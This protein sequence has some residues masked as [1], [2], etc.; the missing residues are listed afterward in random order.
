MPIFPR[1]PPALL[2]T[3][4]ALFVLL[5]STALAHSTARNP[6]S[7]IGTV[8]DP[9]IDT[10]NHRIHA[11]SNFA[12]S[13]TLHGRRVR[14]QLEPNHN[15]IAPGATVEYI[16]K[17]GL[18]RHR[19]E[20]NREEHKVF[21]G[22][23]YFQNLDGSWSEEGLAR[24]S[25]LRDGE[26]PLFEGMFTKARDHHHIQVASKFLKKKHEFDA[27]VKAPE[28]KAPEEFM[29]IFRDSDR[30]TTPEHTEFKRDGDHSACEA[31][32]L[33]FNMQEDHPIYIGMM[34]REDSEWWSSPM[35]SV[36]S[37]RQL[38][39]Q[40]G[41]NS[42]GGNLASTIGQTAGCPTTRKVALIG[43]ATDCTYTSLFDNEEAVR[44]Q[45]ISSVNSASSLFERTFD[46]SLGLRNLTISDAECPGSPT[47]TA[48]W[49]IPCN[50]PSL[51]NRLNSFSTWR[52]NRPDGNSHWTL[53]TNCNTG[54]AVGLA[55]LGQLCVQGLLGNGTNGGDTVSGANVVAHTQAEWEVLAHETGHTFGAVHD[56]EET[57]C[58]DANF[59]NSQ[60]CCPLN[61]N[62]CDAKAKYIMNPATAEGITDFSPCSIGNICSAML[63]NSV[64]TTCLSS[65]RDVTTITGQQC[66]N[67]IVEEGEDCDCG[68]EAACSD[69]ACCD[70]ATCRFKGNAV[71][72]DSN[73]DCCNNCQLSSSDTVCRP[74]RGECD[75]EERC[76]GSAPV[77][78]A[79]VTSPDG[80]DCTGDGAAGLK[81]ASG[82]CTSR[83]QQCKNVM[84]TYSQ[85]NDTHACD[86]YTCQMSCASP[87]FGNGV[88]YS[89]QQNMLDG[90]P[91]G[92]GGHCVNGLCKGSTVGNEIKSWIDEHR[93]LVIGL[94]AGIG[95]F[96]LILILA[97]IIRSCRRRSQRKK[98]A[99]YRPAPSSANMSQ[100]HRGGGGGGGHGGGAWPQYSG[101][102]PA[103]GVRGYPASPAGT[104]IPSPPRSWPLYGDGGGGGPATMQGQ[105]PWHGGAQSTRYA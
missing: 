71:C 56:C 16:G 91:C 34:K 33:Q 58:R 51:Q 18:V 24:M 80:Q 76:T 81:C 31:D 50:G 87:A 75:P 6:L 86:A 100:R 48:E 65:N 12:L 49:N 22:H 62:V 52:G 44:Q 40:P 43:I 8:A 10:R 38:D 41:G 73:E 83:D 3:L 36:F 47:P 85:G 42:A 92:G 69:N 37:K 101:G 70:A 79:D 25:V 78:P 26:D 57:A 97:C 66:G 53:M 98:M 27:E 9:S 5:S 59:V 82:Q 88:C 54:A 1:A 32:K 67:G 19:Q 102:H 7:R 29:V 30:Q 94:A 23:A 104:D 68:G 77:C 60:Q 93:T 74:G 84:G 55:W 20:I 17:D 4:L 103:N 14:L 45:V 46:I 11:F 64:D 61:A 2:S 99:A 89:L 28:G 72:D 63:R 39:S 21:K 15:V 35:G 105:A 90:S 13:F 95:G 96:L